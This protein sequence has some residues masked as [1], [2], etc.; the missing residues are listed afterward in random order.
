M[1]YIYMWI[2]KFKSKEE[3]N[4]YN[5]R[6]LKYNVKL[7]FYSRN[8]Y[9]QGKKAYFIN[10]GIII[11][12]EKN[13]KLFF[14]DLKKEKKIEELEIN[15]DFFISIYSEKETSERV[16]AVKTVYNQKIIFL[17]PAIFDEE[18]WEE[19]EIHH[20]IERIL[21]KFLKLLKM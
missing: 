21:R 20:L 12:K 19:W 15:K 6:T 13:K 1:S 17:K 9:I 4:I 2:L 10:S 8:Y 18:G 16:K 5:Q 11:G 3:W 7:Q 14:R